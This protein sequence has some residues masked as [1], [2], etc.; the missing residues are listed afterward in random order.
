MGLISAEL[1]RQLISY[2]PDTGAMTW[3]HRDRSLCPSDW[4]WKACNT[5]F[6]GKPALVSADST[7][8]LYGGILGKRYP[9]HRIAWL[10]VYGEHPRG[11]IDHI[12]G[13]PSDNRI[14]NLRD[15]LHSENLKNQ[16]FRSTNTSGVMGVSWNKRE[17]KW[18]AY[19]HGD[20]REKHIGYFINLEDAIAARRDAEIRYGYHQNHGR[21]A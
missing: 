4:A 16:R 8:H 9:A 13:D 17:L 14:C 20:N 12:N 1:A 18:R 3:K 5:R 11:E 10:I 19:I 21:A 2:D 7:G 15:V 6:A